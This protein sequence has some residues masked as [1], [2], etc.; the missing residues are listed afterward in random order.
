MLL[1]TKDIYEY[2]KQAEMDYKTSF[3]EPIEGYQWSMSDH[4]NRSAKYKI[5]ETVAGKT[6]MTTVKN[7]TLPLL[8]LQYRM[9]GFNVSDVILFARNPELFYRSKIMRWY[10]E[11][12]ARTNK[13]DKAIDDSVE[14]DVDFGGT[15]LKRTSKKAPEV[16]PLTAI[17]FA[18]QNNI[19]ATPLGIQHRMTLWQI[20]NMPGWGDKSKGASVTL[21]EFR[22]LLADQH[23][24]A[25]D[26]ITVYE[27]RGTMPNRWLSGGDGLSMQLQIV[28]SVV[29]KN[30]EK[31]YVVLLKTKSGNDLKFHSARERIPGRALHLGGVEE[32]FDPQMWTSYSETRLREML[33]EAATVFYKTTDK[34]FGRRQSIKDR[35]TGQVYYVDGDLMQV[36]NSPR[37]AA[38]FHSAIDRWFANAQGMADAHSALRGESPVSGTPAALQELVVTTGKGQHD[39]RQEKNADFW[40]EVYDEWILPGI[41]KEISTEKEFFAELPLKE[42]QNIA[43]NLAQ[44]AVNRKAIDRILA[45]KGPMQREE[46]DALRQS[47]ELDFAKGGNDRFLKILQDEFKGQKLGVKFSIANRQVNIAKDMQSL[48]NVF[49]TIASTGGEILTQ[50]GMSDLLTQIIELSGLNPIDFTS[51]AQTKPQATSKTAP[52][53]DLAQPQV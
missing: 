17:A 43:R 39:Y 49:R 47:L 10:H 29:N 11:D 18:G 45:G 5:G 51:F 27:V 26:K 50:P 19:M 23:K 35:K 38:Q 4:I 28:A 15:L 24:G 9:E 41:A 32:L 12:W 33:D 37:N 7:I 22:A 42:I 14:S 52:I 20:E 13:I 8:R 44:R 46:V 48:V 2:I 21:D 40:G 53:E 31:D 30:K 16:V 36:D 3:A 34:K 1:E 6:D 25:G